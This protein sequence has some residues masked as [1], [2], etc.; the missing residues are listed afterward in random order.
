MLFGY[1]DRGEP[2]LQISTFNGGL[3]DP[4]KHPFLEKFSVGD[5]HLISALDK[6]ARV[7]K[8]FIIYRDLAVRHL[9]T[10]Y[11][12]LLEHHLSVD[13]PKPGWKI[14][15]LND[16]GERKETGSYY[17]PDYIVKY[18]VEQAVG[19]LL[20]NAVADKRSEADCIEAVFNIKVLDPSMGSG[21]F[22]VEAVEY[23]AR[24]LVNLTPQE[25]ETGAFH[26]LT[27]GNGT[28]AQS[29]IYGVDLN[30]LAVE[31]A[32]STLWLT[33]V[34]QSLPLSFLDHH[35]RPGNTLVGARLDDL[36]F[37]NEQQP[38]ERGA[39]AKRKRVNVRGNFR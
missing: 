11:E 33:T 36:Q 31:L 24:Y 17:T 28:V 10:I 18:I 1:I 39:K 21:H 23:I 34:A 14:S 32:K 4:E 19:P 27:S 7:G 38:L 26:D 6:L 29:C 16:K 8:Q 25:S 12:G 22:L 37:A 35:L 30:P 13:A 2:P 20:D 5:L 3:F 9:G 15:L